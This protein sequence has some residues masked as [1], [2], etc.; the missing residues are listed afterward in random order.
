MTDQI[1]QIGQL[2]NLVNNQE[3]II[4]QLRSRTYIDATV[5]LGII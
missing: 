4:E 2:L 3:T 5:D 1:G